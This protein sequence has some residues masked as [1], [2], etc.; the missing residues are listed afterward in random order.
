MANNNESNEQPTSEELERI[1][2]D[3]LFEPVHHEGADCDH[4]IYFLEHFKHRPYAF[5]LRYASNFRNRDTKPI[6]ESLLTEKRK[7]D[8]AI[9]DSSYSL[10]Y[11]KH[12]NKVCV[13]QI[14]HK[15]VKL[16]NN[17]QEFNTFIDYIRPR[18][19]IASQLNQFQPGYNLPFIHN[20]F[21]DTKHFKPTVKKH[22]KTTNNQTTN[23]TNKE[24]EDY[25]ESSYE[26]S[27]DEYDYE[28]DY[29]ASL[30]KASLDFSFDFKRINLYLK[31]DP[32]G[33]NLIKYI[34][35]KLNK[36]AEI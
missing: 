1:C 9:D 21:V 19:L 5:L 34:Q 35:E 11:H 26:S 10:Y 17:E 7:E 20:I 30:N 6:I 16:F 27:D 28:D 18:I 4:E 15:A 8:L 33:E 31:F 32:N 13:Y 36:L 23:E 29:Y 22:S 24:E 14:K 3:E 25:S 2:L 12:P